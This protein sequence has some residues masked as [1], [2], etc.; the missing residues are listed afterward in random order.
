MRQGVAPARGAAKAIPVRA[1]SSKTVG[2]QRK[3][4]TP[5][6]PKPCEP[7]VQP[8][9]PLPRT[10]KTPPPPPAPRAR[11]PPPPP[12]FRTRLVSTPEGRVRRMIP[13]SVCG[14]C[15][16]EVIATVSI[17]RHRCDIVNTLVG[18]SDG[19]FCRSV[20]STGAV[21]LLEQAPVGRTATVEG[22]QS[23][24]RTG[25]RVAPG[26]IPGKAE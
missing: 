22:C 23:M 3:T 15:G 12:G 13:V 18:R 14:T 21:D 8:L 10:R 5:R 19:F 24:E 2:L 7:P 1:A 16:P 11:P 17:I 26:G 6:N 25:F 20:N 9:R 4:A